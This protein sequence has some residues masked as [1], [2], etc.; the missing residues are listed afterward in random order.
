MAQENLL[1]AQSAVD[2]PAHNPKGY[3]P[4]PRYRCIVY[5]HDDAASTL[6]PR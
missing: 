3:E 5:S 1:A 4:K 2:V 6:R